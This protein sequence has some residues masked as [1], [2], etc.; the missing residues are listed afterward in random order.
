MWYFTLE[1][2]A[3]IATSIAKAVT[4]SKTKNKQLMK[5]K[6]HDLVMTIGQGKRVYLNS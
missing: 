6:Q 5:Q 1:A 3:G 4:N 2:V